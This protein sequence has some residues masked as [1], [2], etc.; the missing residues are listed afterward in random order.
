[1]IKLAMNGRECY[2][3]S[4]IEKAVKDNGGQIVTGKTETNTADGIP[5]GKNIKKAKVHELILDSV[6]FIDVP[7]L[8]TMAALQYRWD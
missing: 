7:V 8:K 5:K 6:V 4:G 2:K 1:M 3:N